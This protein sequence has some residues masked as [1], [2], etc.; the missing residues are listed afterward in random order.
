MAVKLFGD[1][2]VTFLC[3]PVGNDVLLTMTIVAPLSFLISQY[4]L[5]ESLR[6]IFG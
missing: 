3:L 4:F 2:G 1:D 6:E 5:I